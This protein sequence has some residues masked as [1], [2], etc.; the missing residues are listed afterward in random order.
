[1]KNSDPKNYCLVLY[2]LSLLTFLGFVSTVLGQSVI[3]GRVVGVS[4]G[5]T[6]KVLHDVKQYKIR[7]Y[8]IDTP[9]KR[10]DFGKKAKQFT[11]NLV[12]GKNVKVIAETTDRYG[13]TVG[14]VY[15]DNICLNEQIITNG[16]G[17]VY[18][19]YCDKPVC[20][21]WLKL[22]KNAKINSLGLWSNP[23]PIPP[24]QYRH[25]ESG[26][27]S[28]LPLKRSHNILYHGNIKSKVFHS[29]GCRYYT[30]K[31]CTVEF[32]SRSE[33]IAAGYRPGGI[34]KP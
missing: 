13:R 1:M 34:C 20:G 28:N 9:E 11:S 16:Y 32:K 12:F 30:C 7:L 15:V 31:N 26:K 10:Q 19:K 33:A 21:Y 17:W 2:F 25:T 14:T 23:N 29:P 4:D 18:R 5:D 8:G 27:T 24:W 22:E 6:I 3:Y